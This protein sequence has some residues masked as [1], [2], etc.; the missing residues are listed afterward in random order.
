MLNFMNVVIDTNILIVANH[1]SPKTSVDN[2]SACINFLE[3]IKN[4]GGRVSVDSSYFI[5]QEYQKHCNHK[6]QPGLGDAFFKWLFDRQGMSTV[7]EFV[8]IQPNETRVF[9]EFPDDPQLENFDKSDRKFVAVAKKSAFKPFIYNATDSDWYIF[10]KI[11]AKHDIK[12]EQ[13]CPNLFLNKDVI[14]I[15]NE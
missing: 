9:E 13:L 2:E 3:N 15:R 10:S 5:F 6:G 11:L 12:V 7:C 14:E 8:P 1:Q 4:E